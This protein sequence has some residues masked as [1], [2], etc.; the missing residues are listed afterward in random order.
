M[1][2]LQGYLGKIVIPHI[3]AHNTNKIIRNKNNLEITRLY[4]PVIYMNLQQSGMRQPS[5]LI[6]NSLGAENLFISELFVMIKCFW[7]ASELTVFSEINLDTYL[8][9]SHKLGGPIITG[10]HRLKS[11]P[12]PRIWPITRNK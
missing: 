1:C 10:K 3:Q 11:F 4:L 6:Y 2:S 7:Q 5:I 12:V 8:F 9:L